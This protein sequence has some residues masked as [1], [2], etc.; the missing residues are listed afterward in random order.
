MMVAETL[1]AYGNANEVSKA[2]A[3]CPHSGHTARHGNFS[4]N[5]Y[6]LSE[7]CRRDRRFT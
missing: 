6:E 7:E 1:T 5:K 2:S 4:M 3:S